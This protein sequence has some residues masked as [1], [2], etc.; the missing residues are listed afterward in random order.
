MNFKIIIF[1]AL[2]LYFL[3]GVYLYLFQRSFIYFPT[4]EVKHNGF[5]ENM[6]I[7]NE[8]I[9][10]IVLN[11]NK[12]NAILYF[13]GRSESVAQN[14]TN[15]TK[16]FPHHTIYL[17]NYRAYGGSTGIPNEKN[18]YNDAIYIYKNI[19][20]RHKNISLIGRSL[21][22]GIATYLAS[23]VKIK[24]MVLV[25]PYDSILNMAKD[26][27]PF[28]PITYILKDQYNSIERVSNIIIP[29]MIFL[30]SSDETINTRYSNN[31]IK[32][33]NP[34]NLSVKTIKESGHKN[35]IKK[36]EYF[37]ELNKFLL[38]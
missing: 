5:V 1:I 25:T 27:Y 19:A 35:I 22:T 38:K 9:K 33:F 21:G 34:L 37:I 11:K 24:K 28:Y 13:G 26:K 2:I 30:A 29:T 4:K 20:K 6:K 3:G 17:V 16:N 14:I 23:N 36:E 15:F 8:N 7:E 10:I 31:L 18:L 32:E 12:E